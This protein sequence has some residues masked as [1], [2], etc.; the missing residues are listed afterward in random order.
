MPSNGTAL[1]L[2]R[3]VAVERF[4]PGSL[5]GLQLWLDASDAA[6]LFDATT[7]G[8]AVTADATAVARWED[9][10]G[11]GRHATQ[12]TLLNRPILK[13]GV[14]NNRNAL[15]FDGSNDSLI[16]AAF[17]QPLAFTVCVAAKNNNSGATQYARLVE[18]GPNT[19]MSIYYDNTPRIFSVTFAASGF[20]NSGQTVGTT[21]RVVT[22]YGDDVSPTRGL[23]IQIDGGTPTSGSHTKT[24]PVGTAS[25]YIAQFGGGGFYGNQDMYEVCYFNRKLTDSERAAMNDYLNKKWSVY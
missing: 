16:T 6:T 23:G 4:N 18:H 13:T 14:Q 9:K 20:T 7:G 17:D 10:S 25:F 24:A 5:A 1:G 8:N 11:N 21:P 15:R 2:S 19:A 3:T 12:S 22:A